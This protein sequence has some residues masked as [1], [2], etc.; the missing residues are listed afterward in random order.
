MDKIHAIAETYRPF[1]LAKRFATAKTAAY[2]QSWVE[3]L[4]HFACHYRGE[5]FEQVLPR[6]GIKGKTP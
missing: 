4:L 2:M 6:S 1:L 5:S 3:Q